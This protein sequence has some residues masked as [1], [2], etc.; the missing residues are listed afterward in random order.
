[1]ARPEVGRYTATVVADRA[2]V[3]V[4]RASYHPRMQAYVDG[5]RVDTQ[6]VAPGFTGVPL[7]PGRHEVE[8]RYAPY[9]HYAPLLVL[10]ALAVALLVWLDRRGRGRHRSAPTATP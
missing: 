5:R 9:P 1:V 2:A 6:L 7:E 8:F 10:G 3:V 4:L